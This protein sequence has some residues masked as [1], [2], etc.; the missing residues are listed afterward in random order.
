[1]KKHLLMTAAMLA[2]GGLSYAQQ[3]S[4]SAV[5]RAA[6][7]VGS[8]D[9]KTE[10]TAG[11]SGQ[12]PAGIQKS[13][14]DDSEDI[15][16]MLASVTEAA[17]TNG[18]FDDLV[19]RFVDADRNRLNTFANQDKEKFATLNGRIEQLRKDWKEKYNQ[20]FDLKEDVVFGNQFQ[21]F[22]IVQGEIANPALLSNWPVP[23]KSG[24]SADVKVGDTSARVTIDTPAR[25]DPAKP[26]APGDRAGDRNLDKGRNIAIL[27]F[28]ASHGMQELTVSLIHEL[29]DNW[30][31]DVPDSVSGQQ[32]HDQ[33]LAHFTKF[34]EN[35]ANWPADVN[36][37]YRM[38][39][40]H[41]LA[42]V[43][44]IS[45]PAAAK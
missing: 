40:H 31:I 29:P 27:H 37:A 15:R 19:E 18:G 13:S 26:E 34:G 8:V 11:Q 38:A 28:P 32:L 30:K 6:D 17:V 10:G 3:Q 39:A 5:Q 14:K 16:D 36:E 44:N 24:I 12:L 42:A 43:Y 25:P 4:D 23:Q 22:Q 45:V 20:D 21:N 9:V 2:L 35:K 41:V 33:L 7:R 1:M